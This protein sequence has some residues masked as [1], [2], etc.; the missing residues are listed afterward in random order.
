M[1][2]K[3][4]G[5]EEGKVGCGSI[6]RLGREAIEQVG[7]SVKARPSSEQELTTETDGA[8]DVISSVNHMFSLAV[9]ERC[10]GKT[11]VAAR[12]GRERKPERSHQT[13]DCCHT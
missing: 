13:L 12:Y 7:G 4:S 5:A 9:L 1:V 11:S 2:A 3:W 8:H 10:T 6:N